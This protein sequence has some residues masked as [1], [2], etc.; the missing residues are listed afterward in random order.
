MGLRQPGDVLG[1]RYRLVHPLASGGMGSVWCAE[2]LSLKSTVALKML[3]G[4][5]NG[6]PAATQR[7]LREARLAAALRSPHVVQIFDYG[8]EGE[9]PY[10]AMELLEGELL[11]ERLDRV[12]RLSAATTAR[13]IRHVSRAM[14]KAH[15]AGIVHRDLKP[16]N[17]FVVKNDD[18]EIYKV[19]DF[20]IA[21]THPMGSGG[22]LM[23]S[24]RTGSLLGTPSYMSPEQAQGA[25]VIDHRTDIWALGVIAYRCL[26]GR[27]PFVGEN[28][29]QLVLAICAEPL[30]KPSAQGAVPAGFDA[31][32]ARACARQP[33]ARFDSAKEAANA[34]GALAEASSALPS[35]PSRPAER[36]A[37]L[38]TG[39]FATSQLLAGPPQA[40]VRKRIATPLLLA[41]FVALGALA[42]SKLSAD[43]QRKR[44]QAAAGAQAVIEQAPAALRPEEKPSAPPASPQIVTETPPA[45]AAAAEQVAAP[46][47]SAAEPSPAA[48]GADGVP[49]VRIARGV[50][51]VRS[52]KP[53]ETEQPPAPTRDRNR[54][55]NEL[56]RR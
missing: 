48:A 39:Q 6:D 31:W 18:E 47:A 7:F 28:V 20:G 34:F 36:G 50:Q 9:T 21:K 33:Q 40:S 23:T 11:G 49:G 8:V 19:F 27:L 24:T 35:E 16:E 44:T 26:L 14:T 22:T 41:A 45:V 12:G 54:R 3:D 29:G 42:V 51:V 1:E 55:T 5:P 4:S 46:P 13:V 53:E 10:I 52:P 56:D 25:K 32:F 15:E 30:P 17:V 2:H 38:T 43:A 37:Q